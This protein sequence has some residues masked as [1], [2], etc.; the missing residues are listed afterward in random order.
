MDWSEA[1]NYGDASAIVL[2]A[3]LGASADFDDS[4]IA[5]MASATDKN[6][7]V[8]GENGAAGGA[9][10]DAECSGDLGDC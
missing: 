3:F 6:M 8:S 5:E 2:G 4:Y 1:D 10:C 9:L 7:S